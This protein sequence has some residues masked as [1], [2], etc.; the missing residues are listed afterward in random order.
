MAKMIKHWFVTGDTH[1]DNLHRINMILASEVTA[2][3]ETGIIILG[4]AGFNYYCDRREHHAKEK[5]N[6]LGCKVYCVRGN[7]EMR[8]QDVEGMTIIFDDEVEGSVYVHPDYPN[9]RY[10]GDYCSYYI[11]GNE[12]LVIGGAYSVD[13]YWRLENGH[14]W[15]HNEQLSEAEMKDCDLI[16]SGRKF[17]FVLTHTC[18]T[19]FQPVDMFLDFIDQSLVDTSM[20]D[21]MEYFKNKIKWDYWLFGHYH[22]DRCQDEHVEIF[23]HWW[24]KLDEIKNRWAFLD[25]NPKARYPIKDKSKLE[26]DN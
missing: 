16:Y 26:K 8:P 17:H 12:V 7:H 25:A 21:W 23:F 14:K 18:P 5:V 6:K 10:F 22:T 3:E 1:G 11:D 2:P 19:S 15:F 4:D 13:K 24:D 9:I 20:E